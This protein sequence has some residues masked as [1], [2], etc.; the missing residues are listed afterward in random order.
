MEEMIFGWLKATHLEHRPF[1][2]HNT[3]IYAIG[4]SHFGCLNISKLP[5]RM[6]AWMFFK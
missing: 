4:A 1:S 6:A 2:R 5:K 3:L